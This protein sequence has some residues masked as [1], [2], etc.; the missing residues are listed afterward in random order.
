M[1]FRLEC[2]CGQCITLHT[3]HSLL[4][5]MVIAVHRK[6][7][8]SQDSHTAAQ[9]LGNRGIGSIQVGLSLLLNWLTSRRQLPLVSKSV[10]TKNSN[11]ETRL[12]IKTLPYF[13][14]QMGNL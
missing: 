14:F 10:T 3:E 4:V 12:T 11:G 13:V 6:V 5:T 7:E 9:L 2:G 8:K 1:L